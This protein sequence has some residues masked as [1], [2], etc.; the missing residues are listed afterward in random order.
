M[1]AFTFIYC[2]ATGVMHTMVM[3]WM[4][5]KPKGTRLYYQRLHGD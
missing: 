3:E 1:L 4:H 2:W 5:A